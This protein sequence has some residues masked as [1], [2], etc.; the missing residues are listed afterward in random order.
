VQRSVD[1]GALARAFALST[2]QSRTESAVR[3]VDDER[4]MAAKFS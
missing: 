2:P 1:V 4:A 3:M